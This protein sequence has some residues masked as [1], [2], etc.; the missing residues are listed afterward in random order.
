MYLCYNLNNF[1]KNTKG[2]KRKIVEG[3]GV[4]YESTT[5]VSTTRNGTRTKEES[6]PN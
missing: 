1:E 6:E 3:K 4:S 2:K 5:L